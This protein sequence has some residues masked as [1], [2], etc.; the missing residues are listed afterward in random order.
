[1]SEYRTATVVIFKDPL[2]MNEPEIVSEVM[3]LRYDVVHIKSQ[4][5]ADAE[6]GFLRGNDWRRR[7]GRALTPKVA[8]LHQLE[9]FAHG[10]RIMV[11]FP[12]LADKAA[13]AAQNQIEQDRAAE[14]RKAR[15]EEVGQK[16]EAHVRRIEEIAAAKRLQRATKDDQNREQAAMFVKA[17]Y[18]LYGRDDCDK[19]WQK[20]REMFP[21][22]PA[23]KLD[24]PHEVSTALAIYAVERSGAGQ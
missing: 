3:Q 18:R 5:N 13:N 10:Q 4:L 21:D 11:L 20:A 8:R 2:E 24:D 9:G 16:H 19:I 7:A 22:I 1:M 12:R 6:D 17:A 14:R 23:W 15:A